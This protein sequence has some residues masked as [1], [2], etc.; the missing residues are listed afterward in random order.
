M[1]FLRR[2]LAPISTK[3][4]E[5]IEDQAKVS[6]KQ[7]LSARKIVDISGPKGW[8]YAAIPIGRIG[9]CDTK[10]GVNFGIRRNLPMIEPRVSF[11]LN[12]WE[13][14]NMAR[15]AE[16]IDLSALEEAA[17]RIAEFEES[18]IYEG[19]GKAGVDGFFKAATN[20]VQIGKNP[21]DWLTSFTKG[22]YLLRDLAIEG[23]YALILPPAMWQQIHSH[24]ECYPL[25]NKLDDLL[26]GPTILSH[27]ISSGLL[28][29]VR[30]GD[31]RLTLGSDYAIGFEHDTK[32]DVNLFLT[33]TF[34]FQ[35]LEPSAF[36]V[37]KSGK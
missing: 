2:G 30:G 15:G 9:D 26:K 35:I 14:D 3:A 17:K 24:S 5:A 29:S 22:V 31:F 1:D 16:D 6:L 34:S 27:F 4:W 13:L 11:K 36:V 20:M 7:F 21:T 23:P 10:N 18:V 8:D 25:K 33:E 32:E 12:K 37:M 19:L 28:V